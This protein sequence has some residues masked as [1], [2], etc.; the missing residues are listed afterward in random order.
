MESG[1]QALRWIVVI[2][3][4]ALGGTGVYYLIDY[5][6]TLS[7]IDV[8]TTFSIEVIDG[9]T[10]ESLD[11]GDFDY[12]LYGSDD[13]NDWLS[14]DTID[15]G[16]GLNKISDSDLDTDDYTYFVVAY[17]G[18]RPNSDFDEEDQLGDRTYYERWAQLQKGKKNTLYAYWQPSSAGI[19]AVNQDSFAYINVA[20]SNITTAANATFMVGTN[21]TQEDSAYVSGSNYQNEISDAPSIVI[22]FNTTVALSDFSV[23]G[24]S[25]SRVNSTAIKYSFSM[26]SP[27]VQTFE[28]NWDPDAADIQINQAHLQWKDTVLASA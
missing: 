9:M 25:K 26:L 20:T 10:L 24:T 18:T 1:K 14:F 15:S 17:N 23:S 22:H 8:P 2:A 19:V 7:A 4:I 12:T 5:L 16:S 13:L 27:I 21:A 3:L 28:G 6:D 11:E